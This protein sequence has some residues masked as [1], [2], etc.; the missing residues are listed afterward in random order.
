MTKPDIT[1][2]RVFELIAAYGAN[3][4]HWPSAERAAA[5][6]LLT[7]EPDRFSDAVEQSRL[8]DT[9]FAHMVP[10]EP[11]SGLAERILTLAPGVQT[12]PAPRRANLW[13]V[14]GDA[15]FPQGLRWPAGAA[16]ASLAMGLVGGYAYAGNTVGISEADSAYAYAF[17]GSSTPDWFVVEGDS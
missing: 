13:S 14:L 2:D 15:L 8:L 11:N 5:A 9:A 16:L 3:P 7:A 12:T 10:P 1:A 4:E 17:G 6:A